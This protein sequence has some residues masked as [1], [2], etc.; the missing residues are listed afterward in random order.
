MSLAY[1]AFDLSQK[2][3]QPWNVWA[4]AVRAGFGAVPGAGPVVATA[5][6][7]EAATRTYAKPAFGLIA[8]TILGETV[9]VH[10]RT[11]L[12]TPFCRLLRFER[13]RS[14]DGDP[15]VLVVAPLSCHHPTLLR[16]TVREILP[17]HDV[18]LTNWVDAR[19]VPL[20][21]GGFGLHDYIDLVVRFVSHLGP[22]VHVLAVCQPCVPVLA[23]VAVM[24]EANAPQ[25]PA[26]MTLMSGPVDARVS[27]TKVD[28]FATEHSMEWL[29][30]MVIHGV[31]R[32]Y[33]GRGRRVYPGALQLQAFMSLDASRH[34]AAH[35]KHWWDVALEDEPA[36]DRH[37]RFYDEY[38]A[39][40]DLP[41]EFYLETVSE[42]FQR[43]SLASGSMVHRGVPVRPA[44]IGRTA[45]LT[46]EG[47]KDDITGLG[48]TRAAHD[49]CS[50]IP[51]PKKQH[52]VQPDVGH[53]GTFSGRGWREG[54]APVFRAFVREHA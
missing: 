30:R 3:A 14:R 17:D 31:P 37:R 52:H 12:E 41:A 28:D 35:Y 19:L 29:E 24:A 8:T 20:S 13:A 45:L 53:Y 15:K 50:G 27:P 2:L 36:A 33:P 39:V 44:A 40:M 4:R 54:I 26:T 10:E 9:E 48:Q 47:A 49:L 46:V 18:Y 32:S 11:V 42:V 38:F 43:F 23:A 1:E 25:Q 5:E 6:V 7:L 16:E 22:D 51:A 34:A 21:H